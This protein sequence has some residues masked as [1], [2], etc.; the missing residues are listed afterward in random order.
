MAMGKRKAQRKPLFVAAKQFTPSAGPPFK[1][2]DTA[3]AA[4]LDRSNTNLANSM[5]LAKLT[6]LSWMVRSGF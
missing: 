3:M 4:K 1:W 5:T 2:E 6:S